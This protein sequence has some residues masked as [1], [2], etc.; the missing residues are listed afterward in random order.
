MRIQVID[1]VH[2]YLCILTYKALE[3]TR[4]S[5]Q[6]GICKHKYIDS[7][8]DITTNLPD[9]LPSYAR[10]HTYFAV[11]WVVGFFIDLLMMN[12]RCQLRK[13]TP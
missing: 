13:M 1:T 2:A 11:A 9:H 6:T 3:G 12:Q 7:N 5:V 10:V 4:A 8:M